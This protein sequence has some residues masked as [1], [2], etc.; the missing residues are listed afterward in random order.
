MHQLE[1]TGKRDIS[2]QDSRGRCHQLSLLW[3]KYHTRMPG[4]EAGKLLQAQSCVRE[5]KVQTR[6]TATSHHPLHH[7][8][9]A[10][11]QE[12][13]NN[14]QKRHN[15]MIRL[16]K[17]PSMPPPTAAAPLGP[18]GCWDP[19]LSPIPCSVPTSPCILPGKYTMFRTPHPH[20]ACSPCLESRSPA[21]VPAPVTAAADTTVITCFL[22]TPSRVHPRGCRGLS[23][24]RNKEAHPLL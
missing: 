7:P 22:P 4:W 10:R 3:L 23:A 2:H 8:D 12:E 18:P 24:T 9:N 1:K 19:L 11:M 17:M 20:E 13:G 5:A 14:E 6:A 15:P 21:S 16:V